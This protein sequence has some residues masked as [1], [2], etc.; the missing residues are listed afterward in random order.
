MN[1]Y[2]EEE[3]I[4]KS[5]EAYDENPEIT[6]FLPGSGEEGE[7]CGRVDYFAHNDHFTSKTHYCGRYECPRCYEM[8]WLPREASHI[9]E[10]L[11]KAKKYWGLWEKRII[12]V[13]I[14]A[15]EGSFDG[16]QMSYSK[17]RERAERLLKRSGM[18]GG[19]MIYHHFRMPNDIHPL[20]EGPHF[21]VFGYGWIKDTDK[22]FRE[23]GWV[24]K[25]LGIRKS[26][27]ESIVYVLSHAT[28]GRKGGILPKQ[29]GTV[30]TTVW[31]GVL[32][33]NKM[34]I[35]K[36]VGE[37]RI[38]CK[39]CDSDFPESEFHRIV[40]IGKHKESGLLVDVD[41]ERYIPPRA[42]LGKES[43]WALEHS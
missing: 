11:T 27:R 10:R 39:F 35:E 15:P 3:Q 17:L 43:W 19:A 37:K 24:I 13:V 20:N 31:F 26:E 16:D 28:L 40:L 42:P 14:S 9:H 12:H 33:Y 25:N 41:W 8:S 4:V 22:I 29:Q 2:N 32:S 30:L 6:W 34:R 7:G 5:L 1:S 23:T 18:L 38:F 36:E 21:H